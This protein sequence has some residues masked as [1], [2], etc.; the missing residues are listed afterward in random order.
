MRFCI[1]QSDSEFLNYFEKWCE[2]QID[3]SE[4][5]VICGDFNINLKITDTYSKRIINIIRDL[6]MK[7]FVK[8]E[9]RVTKTSKTLIDL[10]VS[11][12]FNLNVTV[13]TNDKISDHSTI[14]FN[15]PNISSAEN[16]NDVFVDRLIN[17]SSERFINELKQINWSCDIKRLCE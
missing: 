11:N 15:I 10:V 4:M 5:N 2:E 1:I 12:N 8:T 7:Q 14:S 3:H 6:G 13:Q 9:T 17:Y 16:N